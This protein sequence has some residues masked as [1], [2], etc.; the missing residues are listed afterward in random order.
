MGGKTAGAVRAPR[1]GVDH[2]ARGLEALDREEHLR[3]PGID[4]PQLPHPRG[5]VGSRQALRVFPHGCIADDL[6]D[7]AGTPFEF[8][9]PTNTVAVVWFCQVALEWCADV[10]IRLHRQRGCGGIPDFGSGMVVRYTPSV[11]SV[12]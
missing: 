1:A 6:D 7:Q 5:V 2:P 4:E 8:R 3:H 9:E 10:P 12:R 11:V